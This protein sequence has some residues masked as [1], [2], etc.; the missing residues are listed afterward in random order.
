[1]KR[2][3]LA[4]MMLVVFLGISIPAH[5]MSRPVIQVA[6]VTPE[7]LEIG[8][9]NTIEINFENIGKTYGKDMSFTISVPEGSPFI[10]KSLLLN[11]YLSS[12]NAHKKYVFKY[13]FETKYNAKPGI[14]PLH[15]KGQ[16]FDGNGVDYVLDEVI[17]L[18]LISNDYRARFEL[19][20]DENK[21]LFEEANYT[22]SFI[23]KNV[24][25]TTIDFVEVKL[26]PDQATGIKAKDSEPIYLETIARNSERQFEYDFYIPSGV[27]GYQEATFLI[28]YLEGEVHKKE[29][30]TFYYNVK[31][32]EKNVLVSR[33]SMSHESVP[34]DT[35]FSMAVDV[36]N[37]STKVAKDIRVNVVQDSTITVVSDSYQL[38]DSLKPGETKQVI[39]EFKAVKDSVTANYPINIEVIS[40]EGNK[41][42]KASSG[43][44]IRNSKKE[45]LSTPRVLID[46]FHMSKEKIYV[47]DSFDLSMNIL[48]TSG[49]K[50]IKNLKVLIEAFDATGKNTALIPD[51]TS[52]SMYVGNLN[53]GEQETVTIPYKIMAS[54]NGG[55]YSLN[56]KFEYE[57][58]DHHSFSDMEIISLPIYQENK[59]TLSDV[60][61]GKELD[62]GYTLELDF[63]NTGK[64]D[65]HN[66]MVDIEGDFE[67]INSNYYVGDFL[68]GRMDVYEVQL[69]GALPKT[70]EG[71]IKFSYDDTFG[72]PT[73]KDQA[74]KLTNLIKGESLK[75]DVSTNKELT[76]VA[77][78]KAKINLRIPTVLVGL[79]SI[80]LII[81]GIRFVRKR[82]KVE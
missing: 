20:Y 30:I 45:N 73:T 24:G 54:A 36:V 2:I 4:I 60:R 37:L 82:R 63:Y 67:A 58:K 5:A 72:H 12:V 74:F 29:K 40:D 33:L 43:I 59:L 70:V 38:I 69:R 31:P 66:M 18:K 28:Y 48:N 22:E 64:I 53:V 7:E 65:I 76:E 55:M 75:D 77:S 6:G 13:D 42:F 80:V 3:I 15:I 81:G 61:I 14:Y 27:I 39:F 8:T 71:I 10:S 62:S 25:A 32:Q 51:G 1:M 79:L 34:A 41:V 35:K 17:Y 68:S 11:G 23:I 47:G 16:Y 57:D 50:N 46:G 52:N 78:K 9:T 49:E 26:D 19:V 21:L 44:Y 56:I